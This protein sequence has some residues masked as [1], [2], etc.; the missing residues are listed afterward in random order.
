MYRKSYTVHF[1]GDD[2]IQELNQNVAELVD[3]NKKL[4]K[5]DT[6]L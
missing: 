1:D 3:I 5:R 2:E 6:K 4:E